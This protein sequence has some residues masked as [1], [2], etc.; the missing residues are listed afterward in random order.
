[1]CAAVFTVQQS[2]YRLLGVKTS[3]VNCIIVHLN[4]DSESEKYKIHKVMNAM[5]AKGA[6]YIRLKDNRRLKTFI[7]NK[8]QD[9][10]VWRADTIQ[11]VIAAKHTFCFR[12]LRRYKEFG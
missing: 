6:R 8:Q 2:T 3:V 12:H 5:G 7:N 11:L 1:M 10:L 4:S 9:G